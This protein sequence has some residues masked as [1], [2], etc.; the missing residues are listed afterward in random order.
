MLWRRRREHTRIVWKRVIPHLWVSRPSLLGNCPIEPDQQNTLVVE[1]ICVRNDCRPGRTYGTHHRPT[2]GVR[3]HLHLIK[4]WTRYPWEKAEVGI[5]RW[6]ALT[7]YPSCYGVA[8]HGGVRRYAP[9]G[10]RSKNTVICQWLFKGGPL[11]PQSASP[12]GFTTHRRVGERAQKVAVWI[13]SLTRLP[14]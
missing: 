12:L 5:H 8:H 1:L 11:A 10:S 7:A 2:G 4:I 14:M 9:D 13:F 6:H 3:H